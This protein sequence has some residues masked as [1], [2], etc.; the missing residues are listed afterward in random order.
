MN[1]DS[2]DSSVKIIEDTQKVVLFKNKILV[3]QES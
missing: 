3:I 1:N 2:T